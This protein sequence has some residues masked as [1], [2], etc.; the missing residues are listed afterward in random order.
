MSGVIVLWW[1][2]NSSLIV[3]SNEH[4]VNP[5]KTVRR[6]L[7]VHK[8]KVTALMLHVISMCN[9]HMGGI[10]RMDQIIFLYEIVN[11]GHK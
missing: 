1:N 3:A 9:C 6:Y 7:A 2:D 8:K 10:D 5:F 4:G 11:R